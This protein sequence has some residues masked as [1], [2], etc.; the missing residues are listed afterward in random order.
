[1]RLLAVARRRDAG[2]LEAVVREMT[3]DLDMLKVDVDVIDTMIRLRGAHGAPP[4][5]RDE[6]VEKPAEPEG[7]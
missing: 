4:V 1:M 6:T 2:E 7:E 5:H 3:R